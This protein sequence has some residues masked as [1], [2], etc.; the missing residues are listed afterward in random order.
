LRC[1]P[2]NPSLLGMRKVCSEAMQEMF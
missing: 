1:D 2:V